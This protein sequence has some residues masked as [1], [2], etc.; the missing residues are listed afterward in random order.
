MTEACQLL[1]EHRQLT[2]TERISSAL[3]H[4]SQNLQ[5]MVVYDASKRMTVTLASSKKLGSTRGTVCADMSTMGRC[6]NN[7]EFSVL[8]NLCT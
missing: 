1:R 8:D 4:A 3:S 2:E 7:L 6:Y 5:S